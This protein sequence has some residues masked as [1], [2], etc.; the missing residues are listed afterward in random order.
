METPKEYYYTYYSYE[1]WGRGYIGSRKCLCSPEED[2]KYFGSYRDKTFHPT[3]KIILGIYKTR[4]EALTAEVILHE[5]YDVANNSNFANKAKQSST[6]FWLPK[7]QKIENGKKGGKKSKEL[8]LGIHAL[9]K[10]QLSENGKKAVRV[11]LA[12]CSKEKLIENGRKTYELGIGIHGL[13]PEQRRE[14]GKKVKELGIGIFG[15]TPEE[16]RENGRKIGNKHKENKTGVCGQSKEK[17][18]ENGKKTGKINAEMN[19][20]NK[21]GIFGMSIEERSKAGKKSKE[22]GLGIHGL[23]KQ[24]MTENGKKGY[25]NG[26]A[27]RT[28]EQKAENTKKLNSQKWMCLETGFIS[29]PGNLTQYQKRRG[30]NTEKRIK[31]EN[32]NMWG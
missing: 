2:V 17:L 13:T 15:M 14:N 27:K 25:A 3:Q 16:R 5:F 24:Q 22:L 9:T 8:G 23:T 31:L 19:R 7:E 20:K 6:K 12:N 11:M 30:I 29:N 1:E 26:L 21:T 28:K 18:I 10:E 4:E 32:C